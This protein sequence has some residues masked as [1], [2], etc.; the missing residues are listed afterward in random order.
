MNVALVVMLVSVV[1]GCRQ[2][3]FASSEQAQTALVPNVLMTVESKPQQFWAVRG[4]CSEM[5]PDSSLA[6]EYCFNKNPVALVELSSTRLP[7]GFITIFC[8]ATK[9]PGAASKVSLVLAKESGKLA[10][11]SWGDGE[12]QI[13]GSLTAPGKYKLYVGFPKG[14]VQ[15]KALVL[16]GPSSLFTVSPTRGNCDWK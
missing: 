9:S 12:T 8:A 1:G 13:L 14:T 5:F 3:E 2:P 6:S 10:E 7:L 11:E 15:E 16:I 4:E